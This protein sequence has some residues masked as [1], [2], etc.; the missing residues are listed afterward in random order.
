MKE[1]AMSVRYRCRLSL[2]AAALVLVALAAAG[3]AQ[4]K[5]YRPELDKKYLDSSLR[6]DWYGV[7]EKEKGKKIGFVRNERKRV[8]DQFVEE[9]FMTMKLVS[10]GQKVEISSTQTMTFEPAPSYRMVRGLLVVKSGG[11]E[12]TTTLSW[13]SEKS[14]YESVHE[15][16]GQKRTELLKDIDY[17]LHDASATEVWVRGNPKVGAV[18]VTRSFDIEEAKI[19]AQTNKVMTIKEALVSGVNVRFFEVETDS[20]IREFKSLSRYDNEGVTLSADVL[21][22]ELRRESEKEAKDTQY[23]QDLFVQGMVK[24][25]QRIGETGKIAELVVE[26]QGKDADGLTDGPRQSVVATDNGRLIKLGKKYGK[27]QKA[28][29]AEIKEA[30]AETNT[31]PI[32]NPRIKE[33]ADKVTE[34]ADTPEEKV[35]KIVA[36]VHKFVRPNLSAESPEIFALLKKKSGDCKSYALLFNNLARAAG[37]P[38][39]EVSGLLYVGDSVKAFGGHAWNEVV[40]GGVWVPVDASMGETEV[41]ATHICFGTEH[42][43]TKNLM[44]TLGKL[45]FRLVEVKQAP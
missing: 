4:E 32:T 5:F 34:G 12:K 24:I 14:A 40:L 23:S 11:N 21:I 10:F 9:Q 20:K 22:F 18:V 39:R 1:P 38:A 15:A 27:E 6:V 16:G 17:T 19:D 45:S 43:A 8:G 3:R 42:R 33:L 30:L 36:F 13:V 28:T 37:V 35:A 7:Y 2:V 44:T 41:N 29:D 25:D 26:V 31:Y